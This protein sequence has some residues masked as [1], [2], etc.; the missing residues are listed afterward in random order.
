MTEKM[1][2][3]DPKT[4]RPIEY[5][6]L[7]KVGKVEEKVGGIYLPESHR[8]KEVHHQIEAELVSFGDLAFT[9]SNGDYIPD[10]PSKGDKVIIA[11]YAGVPSK[12]S[13]GNLYRFANDKDVVA[14]IREA[15]DE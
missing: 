14:I 7:V 4:I 12:D 10:R 1:T 6:I 8:D 15:D 2:V 5:R 13:E 11:K 3:I 9:D